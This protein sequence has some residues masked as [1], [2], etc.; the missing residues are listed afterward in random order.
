MSGSRTR[1]SSDLPDNQMAWRGGV[2]LKELARRLGVSQTTVSRVMNRSAAKYRIA[3]GTE[4]RVLEAAAEL[5]YEPNAFAR[6]LR[7]KSSFTV[8]VMVPEISEGY[9][10][11]VLSGIED[12]L[13]GEKFF[14]F[15]V[16][17][18]H[19]SDLLADYLHLL[20]ARG[21]EGIIA[22]DTPIQDGLPVPVVAVSG[23]RKTKSILTIEID[24]IAAAR[25]ALSHLV[26]LGHREIAF[27][28]GQ[29]FSSDTEAR[30]KAIQKVAASL[31]IGVPSKRVVQLEGTSAGSESGYVAMQRLLSH[32]RP[33]TAVFAFNDISAIGAIAAL[34]EAGLKVPRDISVVGFDDIS[35]A[36]AV[37]P[38]LTTV[39]QP[40]YEMGKTAAMNL[41]ELIGNR[42]RGRRQKPI[43]V[44]PSFVRRQSTDKVR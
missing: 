43:L 37:R 14:Y 9:A 22:V 28:K 27:I 21:V 8:G 24:H 44:S 29:P 42:G 26:E 40:L 31:R 19:R 30:W 18:H 23:H 39:R 6:G 13:L 33:F 34:H 7:K 35:S 32:G 16:S 38:G 10:A 2:S 5:K 20:L 15:V 41:L 12:A 3:A 1:K 4:Q 11:A 36:S 25:Y 17:H